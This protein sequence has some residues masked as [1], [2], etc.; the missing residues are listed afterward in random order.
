MNIDFYKY[1]SLGNDFIL[2][3]C[4]DDVNCNLQP[5]QVQ[6][7]CDRHFGIGADGVLIITQEPNEPIKALILN[8]D[9]SNG[10]VC[11][12]GLRCVAD[13]LVTHKNYPANSTI[14]MGNKLFSCNAN[15]QLTIIV[16]NVNY[17]GEQSIT[18]NKKLLTGHVVNVGNPHFVILQ[19]IAQSWLQ[20][21][22]STIEQHHIFPHKT[23]VEIVYQE[24]EIY[25]LLIHERGCGMTLA[26]GTGA[27]AVMQTL[28]QLDKVAK[29]EEILLQM[30]GGSLKSYL[31]DDNNVIQVAAAACVYRGVIDE[32]GVIT[33][34][35]SATY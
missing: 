13:Y 25:N 4:L 34:S 10:D 11:L 16:P 8:A 29:N 19:K 15:Q 31:D 22:G 21:N 26:C 33:A 35:L 17:L 14:N 18:V 20:T 7:L 12:N 28:Y 27:A 23:N 2:I 1:Q 3:D 6:R 5:Q 30:P 9:G 24:H 32:K